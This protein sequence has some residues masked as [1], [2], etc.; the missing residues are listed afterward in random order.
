MGICSVQVILA[1]GSGTTTK[2]AGIARKL[3]AK[4]PDVWVV[5]PIVADKLVKLDSG[6]VERVSRNLAMYE[7][8]STNVCTNHAGFR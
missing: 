2:S 7:P 3:K 8:C 1:S 5:T 6:N 4:M